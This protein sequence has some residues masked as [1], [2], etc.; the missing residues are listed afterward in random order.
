MGC[1]KSI[2][3][4]KVVQPGIL[5]ANF[6]NQLVK[7]SKDNLHSKITPDDNVV[8]KKILPS[9]E[10]YDHVSFCNHFSEGKSSSSKLC[11]PRLSE[12]VV[13]PIIGPAQF[14]GNSRFGSEGCSRFGSEASSKNSQAINQEFDEFDNNKLLVNFLL[15]NKNIAISKNPNS[16]SFSLERHSDKQNLLKMTPTNSFV[17]D[18]KEKTGLLTPESSGKLESNQSEDIPSHLVQTRPKREIPRDLMSATKKKP[19]LI[20]PEE[21]NKKEK[22]IKISQNKSQKQIEKSNSIQPPKSELLKPR[23]ERVSNLNPPKLSFFN[24]NL[25]DLNENELENASKTSEKEIEYDQRILCENGSENNYDYPQKDQKLCSPYKFKLKDNYENQSKQ[26]S[27]SKKGK[28]S[29]CDLPIIKIHNELSDQ[30]NRLGLKRSLSSVGMHRKDSNANINIDKIYRKDVDLLEKF[31]S[32]QKCA[33]VTSKPYKKNNDSKSSFL[34]NCDISGIYPD[35]INKKNIA[36]SRDN[37]EDPAIEKSFKSYYRSF[38]INQKGSKDQL[39]FQP[40]FIEKELKQKN[41]N[42]NHI[43]P[44]KPQPNIN[45]M[46]NLSDNRNLNPQ[47]NLIIPLAQISSTK[48][49]DSANNIGKPSNQKEQQQEQSNKIIIP[50]HNKVLQQDKFNK[51]NTVNHI[52]NKDIDEDH[53]KYVLLKRQTMSTA[54]YSTPT[55]RM[56][57]NLT[58]NIKISKINQERNSTIVDQNPNCDYYPIKTLKTMRSHTMRN[59]MQNEISVSP[60]KSKSNTSPEINKFDAV[61]ND[62]YIANDNY[63]GVK[64]QKD[65]IAKSGSR[66]AT[67]LNLTDGDEA[68]NIATK[69]IS[70]VSLNSSRKD[71]DSNNFYRSLSVVDHQ[72][73]LL[74]EPKIPKQIKGSQSVNKDSQ[75]VYKGSRSGNKF[76]KLDNEFAM[77]CYQQ[78]Q[79]NS[80]TSLTD[81]GYGFCSKSLTNTEQEACS[82]LKNHKLLVGSS[83]NNNK[84]RVIIGSSQ[85]DHKNVLNTIQELDNISNNFSNKTI[86]YAINENPNMASEVELN[87]LYFEFNQEQNKNHQEKL[88]SCIEIK[89]NTQTHSCMEIKSISKAGVVDPIPIDDKTI[90]KRINYKNGALNNDPYS[91]KNIQNNN[92]ECSNMNDMI[93]LGYDDEEDERARIKHH[94]KFPNNDDS[95]IVSSQGIRLK[96]KYRVNWTNVDDKNSQ[97][98]EK[99]VYTYS[100]I[101]PTASQ[102]CDEKVNDIR[103]IVP[104]QFVINKKKEIVDIMSEKK[105]KKCDSTVQ[106]SRLNKNLEMISESGQTVSIFKYPILNGLDQCYQPKSRKFVGGMYNHRQRKSSATIFSEKYQP[107]DIMEVADGEGEPK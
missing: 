64:K 43:I 101:N 75:S 8:R 58:P 93:S 59:S 26:L 29:V 28:Q 73:D 105:H 15:K 20:E 39:Q 83:P 96:Q 3:S 38:T 84:N 67:L 57:F 97:L 60:E 55:N 80:V 34:Q 104:K 7:S 14:R 62:D 77:K 98:N 45:T 102:D 106:D 107:I 51:R 36:K 4:D 41:S 30:S 89:S 25:R 94:A 66:L 100:G 86:G 85:N 23:H 44:N 87:P 17:N 6:D 79:I 31:E 78:N 95:Q 40:N 82:N 69:H 103:V 54:N 52:K 32:K 10:R 99:K 71:I 22:I 46:I 11:T 27:V 33:I 21:H 81:I 49:D 53:T 18:F 68:L 47:S 1:T 19:V 9:D 63:L 92:L 65:N 42:R 48:F 88:R 56:S 16:L 50:H 5:Q 74:E 76:S 72:V 24:T 61:D 91:E 37:K 70:H 13:K 90:K 2:V 35:N 12:N